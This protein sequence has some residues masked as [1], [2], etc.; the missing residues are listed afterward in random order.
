MQSRT[1]ANEC[2]HTRASSIC[3]IHCSPKKHFSGSSGRVFRDVQRV[4]IGVPVPIGTAS[5]RAIFSRFEKHA[6]GERRGL[7]QIGGWRRKVSAGRIFRHLQ[8][9]TG[10]RRFAVG[11]LRRVLKKNSSEPP[12]R[13]LSN[14]VWCMPTAFLYAVSIHVP[15]RMP[16]HMLGCGRGSRRR[17]ARTRAHRRSTRC[18]AA[19]V[20]E[21]TMAMLVMAY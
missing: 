11:M 17:S 16:I 12:P 8:I 19:K 5:T 6:D 2:S 4:S 10:P 13:E 3:T 9:G 7:D 21:Q 14:D 15:I 1:S 20:Q 18:A